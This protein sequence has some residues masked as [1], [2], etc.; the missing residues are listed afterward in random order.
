[1]PFTLDKEQIDLC[2]D[3]EHQSDILFSLYR[4]VYDGSTVN[5][6]AWAIIEKVDGWPKLGR[7]AWDYICEKFIVHD[8]KHHHPDVVAGGLW[9]NNGFSCSESLGAWECEPAPYRLTS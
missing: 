8:R 1:M 4:L 9:L 2:F 6:P 5:R 7:E 3:H